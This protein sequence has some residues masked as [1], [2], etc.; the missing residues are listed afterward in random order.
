MWRCLVEK[1]VRVDQVSN[2]G[3]KNEHRLTVVNNRHKIKE[4]YEKEYKDIVK[5]W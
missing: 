4:K 2:V 1:N 3:C 5:G